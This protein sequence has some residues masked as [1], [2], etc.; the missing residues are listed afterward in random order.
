MFQS[1]LN[2]LIKRC[3][4]VRLGGEVVSLMRGSSLI[5]PTSK[6]TVGASDSR[7]RRAQLELR[8]DRKRSA[9]AS[10]ARITGATSLGMNPSELMRNAG[11]PLEMRDHEMAGLK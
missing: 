8:S 7:I 1:F 9:C 11:S 3:A 5:C 4:T 2:R 6:C 10:E